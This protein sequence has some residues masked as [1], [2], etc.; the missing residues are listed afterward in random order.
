MLNSSPVVL[1]QHCEALFRM[2]SFLIA[3]WFLSFPI[4]QRSHYFIATQKSMQINNKK[5]K[6]KKR[7]ENV[8]NRSKS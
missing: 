1:K 6:K 3:A 5:I 8:M 4:P 7:K 2:G